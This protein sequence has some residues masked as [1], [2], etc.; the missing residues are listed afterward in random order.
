MKSAGKNNI[1]KKNKRENL[2]E[3]PQEIARL[4]TPKEAEEDT[5]LNF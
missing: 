2:Q 4:Q 5:Q 3:T 1:E